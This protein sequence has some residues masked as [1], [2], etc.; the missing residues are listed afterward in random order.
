MA[1]LRAHGRATGDA[2]LINLWAGQAHALATDEPAAA[3][4]RRLA[5]EARE[6]VRSAPGGW[7]AAARPCAT[8][9]PTPRSRRSCARRPTQRSPAA[10]PACPTLEAA[11]GRLL[12]GDDRLPE[13]L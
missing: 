2:D 3:I 6:A 10:F 13:A 5:A 9:S 7:A 12:F 1:P 11:D 4:T 8:A